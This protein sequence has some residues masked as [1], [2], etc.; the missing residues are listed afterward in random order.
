[1]GSLKSGVF[2]GKNHCSTSTSTGRIQGGIKIETTRPPLEKN[3]HLVSAG[4][5][6]Q[7]SY[8]THKNAAKRK[9][10]CDTSIASWSGFVSG[11]EGEGGVLCTVHCRSR[12]NRRPVHHS[13]AWTEHVVFSPTSQTMRP[14]SASCSDVCRESRCRE[15]HPTSNPLVRRTCTSITASKSPLVF[16][17]GPQFQNNKGGYYVTTSRVPSHYKTM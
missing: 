3:I 12:T 8:E 10:T 9:N 5:C 16:P 4:T 1:M 14:L 17:A 7:H 15:L 2:A 6:I 11:E 13:Y